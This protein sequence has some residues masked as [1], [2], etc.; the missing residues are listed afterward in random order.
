MNLR[1]IKFLAVGSI[2]FIVDAIAFLLCAYI[3]ELPHYQSRS[4][5]FIIALTTTWLGNRLYTFVDIKSPSYGTEWMR[6]AISAGLSAM[7]NFLIF[8]LA[9]RL[10]G[11]GVPQSLSAL[12]LGV[13][14]GAA[15]NYF[16]SSRW[17]FENTKNISK[18]L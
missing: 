10:L 8:S 7:P 2:G 3:F 16:L 4:I 9:L 15:T 1:A 11:E 12:S 13:L 5:A 6:F 14:A 17:V 18:Q